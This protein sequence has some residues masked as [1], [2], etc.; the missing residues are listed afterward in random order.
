M[1]WWASSV[2]LLVAAACQ[3]PGHNR[4]VPQTHLERSLFFAERDARGGQHPISAKSA[5]STSGVERTADGAT[6]DVNS[7]LFLRIQDALAGPGGGESAV[8]PAQAEQLSEDLRVLTEALE[9][10]A[11][12]R[13]AEARALRAW[14]SYD[15]ALPGTAEEASA[16]ERFNEARRARAQARQ[17]VLAAA[18]RLWPVGERTSETD[19]AITKFVAGGGDE[20]VVQ[21]LRDGL[22]ALAQRS[23]RFEAEVRAR[24][25][26]DER[27]LRVEAFLIPSEGAEKQHAVHVPGYDTLDQ[28]EI[29]SIDPLGLRLTQAERDALER[30][31]ADSRKLAEAL[32]KVRRGEETLARALAQAGGPLF[33]EIATLISDLEELDVANRIAAMPKHLEAFLAAVEAASKQ[34]AD[35]KKKAW[36]DAV[37]ALLVESEVLSAAAEEIK[38]ITTLGEDWKRARPE[39]IPALLERSLKA[40]R[41]LDDLWAEREKLVSAAAKLAQSLGDDIAALPTQAR[42]VVEPIWRDSKLRTDVEEW[43][44]RVTRVA[45]LVTRLAEAFGL[46]SKPVRTDLQNTHVIDLPIGEARD[47]QIDLRRTTRK[48]GDHLHVRA[49]L[50]RP[51]GKDAEPALD[52]TFELQKLGWHADLIPSV[53]FVEGD[54]VAGANDSGGFSTALNWMW[55]YGP[56][57]DEDDPKLSRSLDWSLGLHAVF[58]N[59]GPDNDAEIGLGVTGALWNQYLQFG[60][61]Y[62]PMADGDEDGRVYYFIGSSLVPLLQALSRD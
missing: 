58:L 59:F 30:L 21:R 42:A 15:A 10:V 3:G 37:Q 60:V 7:Q 43:R 57:D 50:L 55:S 47:T 4:P 25:A 34:V 20:R 5:E 44:D 53:V 52:A 26:S 17:P 41:E 2:L 56:R 6:L 23:Q 24:A 31:M 45:R 18:R 61:G 36:T 19:D 48:S 39:D 9:N 62:N 46:P 49:T 27:R 11:N 35:D 28:G 8:V 38:A 40:I 14:H 33:A 1:K 51:D 22:S 13:D 16:R 29:K 12:L 54:R 32:E